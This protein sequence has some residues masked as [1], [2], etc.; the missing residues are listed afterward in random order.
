LRALAVAAL[1]TIDARPAVA[2]EVTVQGQRRDPGATTVTP[3]E[4]RDMPGAFGDPARVIEALPGVVSLGSALPFYFVRGA[5]PSNTGFFLDG[6]RLPLFSHGPPG[7]GV[8]NGSAIE[9]VDFYPGAAPP[10]FGGVT[11]A[12]LSVATTPPSARTRGEARAT[13]YDSS[14]LIEAPLDDGRASVLASAR[15]GYTQ[16][17][18]DVLDPSTR[19]GYWDYF[20]RASWIPTPGG[21]ERLS[22]VT[23]G[24]HDSVSGPVIGADVDTTFHRVEVRYDVAGSAHRPSLRVAATA[25][26]NV[27][28]NDIGSVGD[29]IYGVRVESTIPITSALRL[30]TGAS[31]TLERYDV[32]VSTP[33]R[34]PDPQ[35]LFAPRDDLS[36]GGYGDLSWRLSSAVDVDAGARVGMFATERDEYPRSDYSV[37]TRATGLRPPPGAAAKPAVDPRLTARARI[38]RGVAFVGAFGVAHSTPSFLLPGLAQSRLEDGLQTAVQSSA[39]FELALP[40][41]ISA[42]VD[43][44]LHDYLDLSDPTATCPTSTSLLFNPTAACFGRRVRGR[45]FGGELLLR[46]PFTNRLSGWLS[47]TLSRSTRETHA[48]GW[49]IIGANREA[50]VEVLSEW[51]RTH[52]VS[53]MVAYDLGRRW[54]AAARF[55]YATGRPYSHTVNGVFVGPY[56]SDRFPPVYR[57]DLRLSKTWS[58]DGDRRVSFIVEG[59]N[60]TGFQEALECRPD[61]QLQLDPVPSFFVRG[62]AV[63]PCTI[64][65]APALAIPSV[66]LEGSF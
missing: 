65:Y 10:R 7:G 61:A 21:S 35:I 17:L 46:R 32:T 52:S 24:A 19:Q 40:G 64:R 44:F 2:D 45:S 1:V 12:V 43:G 41:Q 6:M 33:A 48:P 29:R 63:D 54:T 26:V 57:V 5:T 36:L 8:V 20:A 9:S 25:G 15:Y 16:L 51:D 30:G 50:V 58:F 53:A 34:S 42:K 11:G 3:S 56:S 28:S 47:Y 59:F 23:V 22:V 49:T 31:L 39:G 14:A 62:R 27:Q 60:V 37:A 55:S 66:G 38:V 4:V 18:L 13:L